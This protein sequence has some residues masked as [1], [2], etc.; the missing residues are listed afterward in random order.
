LKDGVQDAR[1]GVPS[2]GI[3]RSGFVNANLTTKDSRI[4]ITPVILPRSFF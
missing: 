1:G 3:L 2:P 4:L